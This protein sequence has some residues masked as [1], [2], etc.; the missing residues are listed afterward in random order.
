[1]NK[2][3]R[4]HVLLF[5]VNVIYGINYSIAKSLMHDYIQPMGFI[6]LRVLGA[7]SLFFIVHPFFKNEKI[8]KK[9]FLL[10]AACGLFGVAANQLMFFKGLNLTGAIDASLM[11]TTIPL[12]VL[13][14]AAVLIKEMI[15]GKKILGIILGAA[16]AIVLILFSK[17]SNDGKH[18]ILGDL[19]VFLNSFSYAIYLVIAKPLMTKY[20]PLTVIKWTFVFGLPIVMLF[21]FSEL[22]EVKWATFDTNTWLGVAFV[23]IGS[24][25]VV[26]LFNIFALRD[27]SPQVVSIYIYVQPVIATLFSL[28]MNH[29]NLKITQVIASLLIFTGVYLVSSPKIAKNKLT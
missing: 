25:F 2:K 23:V 17:H 29:E 21:G 19:Y 15:T 18:A 22:T 11:I 8:E 7:T 10:F 26:Y 28:S 1:M 27:V 20:H 24:T 4:A 9:D 5:F 16:G 14:V 6:V 12:L 3:V 13:V